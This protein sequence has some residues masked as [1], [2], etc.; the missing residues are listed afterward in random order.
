MMSWSMVSGLSSERPAI[1]WGAL[2]SGATSGAGGSRRL[3]RAAARRGGPVLSPRPRPA[4]GRGVRAAGPGGAVRP[5]V[6]AGLFYPA[7][8]A[9]LRAEVSEL[10]AEAARV[11]PTGHRPKALI[12][13]HAG[14][15]YSGAVAAAAFG[16]LGEKAAQAIRRV[17]VIGPSHH[18]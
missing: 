13:P 5:P 10:L 17:V 1:T 8:P 7:D 3:D 15:A 14:Y 12:V 4:A 2:G 9:R 6:V 16:T 11:A 18:A